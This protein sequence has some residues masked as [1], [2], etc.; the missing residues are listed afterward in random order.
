[1]KI[2]FWFYISSLLLLVFEVLNVYFIMPMPGSQSLDTLAIAYLLYT[3]RWFFRFAIAAIVLYF[4][5]RLFNKSTYLHFVFLFFIGGLIW[6]FNS[7]VAADKM[8]LN[9]TKLIMLDSTHNTVPLDRLIIGV[10]AGGQ[11]K[12]YPIQY[13]G[14]H[15]QVQDT[16]NG[17]PIMITYCNVCRTGRAFQPIVNGK[18]EKFRLVGMDHYNAMFEDASTKTWWRQVSGEAAAGPLKGQ[19]L[20]EVFTE[21]MTLGTWLSIYP[22]SL[23]MQADSTFTSDYQDMESYEGGRSKSG[24]TRYDAADFNK[25]SWVVGVSQQGRNKAYSWN[26]LT[27]KRLIIDSLGDLYFAITMGSDSLSFTC[28]K[29]DKIPSRD[30]LFFYNDTL[31][32]NNN[33]YNW[34]GRSHDANRNDITNIQVYQEYWHSWQ[35]FH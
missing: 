32:Y 8:F 13:L 30:S 29:F 17:S 4:S 18:K 16:L 1:M 20:P 15:H 12:A 33:K 34:N 22:N 35:A 14:Y 24:L 7:N 6:I 28:L 21:Q 11:S 23:V 3:Y 31:F 25:K 10:Q 26:E 5:V 9:I 2:K 19:Q 27:S